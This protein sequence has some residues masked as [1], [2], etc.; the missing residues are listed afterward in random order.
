MMKI[1]AGDIGKPL[2]RIELVPEPE[3]ATAPLEPSV[4]PEVVPVAE[5][6]PA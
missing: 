4:E 5:P 1:S 3:P 6:V 2:R